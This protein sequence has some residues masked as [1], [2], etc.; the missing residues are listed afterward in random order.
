MKI[1]HVVPSY[2]PA[3][4]YGGPIYSVHGL[5]AGQVALGHQVSVFTTNAD[6]PGVSD[7]PVSTSVDMDGVAVTYFEIG[8]PRRLYRA[9]AMGTALKAQAADFDVIHLHSVFLWPT[10]TAARAAKKA[11]TPFILSPRGML[12]ADLIRAKSSLIKRAWLALFEHR[13]IREAAAIHFTADREAIDFDQLGLRANHRLIIPNGVEEPTPVTP[14]TVSPDIAEATAQSGYALYLG[15]LNWKKN[16]VALIDAIAFSP[17]T[18]LI[19]AG[20]DDENHS[21]ELLEAIAKANVGDRVTLIDRGVTGPDKEW[22]FAWCGQFVLPSHNENFGN[23]VLE[24][25]IRGKPVV[26][27]TGAGVAEV[28]KAAGCGLITEP[29]PQALGI[30]IRAFAD[31]PAGAQAMGILGCEAARAHFGWH[32]IA[33]R[34]L[35][36]YRDL[37]GSH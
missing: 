25:M 12:V 32:A 14:D 26:V 5:A 29:N 10:L 31:D 16:L 30:A 34:M 11:G 1:L 6:G 7:V 33:G 23:T 4:R 22:L 20:T 19:I 35:A 37:S 17:A 2:F 13:T 8:S 24:A 9:P 18:R 3:V 27:S 28:V 15:R 21:A 36:A